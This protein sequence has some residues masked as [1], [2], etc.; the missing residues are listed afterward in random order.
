MAITVPLEVTLYFIFFIRFD[1]FPVSESLHQEFDTRGP[2]SCQRSFTVM[3]LQSLHKGHRI[4][5]HLL[6]VVRLRVLRGYCKKNSADFAEPVSFSVCSGRKATKTLTVFY[7]GC[8]VK[9][10]IDSREERETM[11]RCTDSLMRNYKLNRGIVPQ[12]LSLFALNALNSAA[13]G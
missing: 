10:E 8:K 11:R 3:S 7:E 4:F 1:L 2:Q 12:T 13:E 5:Q 9:R 6:I